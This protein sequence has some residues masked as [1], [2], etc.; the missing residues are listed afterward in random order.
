MRVKPARQPGH[1]VFD[2]APGDAALLAG[3]ET[4]PEP[5]VVLTVV[6]EERAFREQLNQRATA[7]THLLEEILSR[8]GALPALEL[9]KLELDRETRPDDRW[10]KPSGANSGGRTASAAGRTDTRC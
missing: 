6:E 7:K 2:L 10:P 3:G 5:D 1:V 4:K 8:S 9:E